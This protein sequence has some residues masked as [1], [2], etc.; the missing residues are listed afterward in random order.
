MCISCVWLLK[1]HVYAFS[2]VLFN[3]R[4][5]EVKPQAY[6]SFL[7]LPTCCTTTFFTKCWILYELFV[8]FLIIQGNSTM[9][10]NSVQHTGC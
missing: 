7:K 5:A 1:E 3:R 10:V 8:P 2:F 9:S 4:L 6:S